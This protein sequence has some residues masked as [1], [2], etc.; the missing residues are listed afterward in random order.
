M[1]QSR[2]NGKSE[3]SDER[4]IQCKSVMILGE[5]KKKQKKEVGQM[6]EL[7]E[8]VKGLKEKEGRGRGRKE[9]V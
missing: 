4:K 6:G 8:R 1:N 9:Q 3:N 7:G 5:R 2:K